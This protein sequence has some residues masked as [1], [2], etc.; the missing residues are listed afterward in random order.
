M[1]TPT[2]STYHTFPAFSPDGRHLA[3][4]SCVGRYSC[5]VAVVE[6][7]ADFVPKGAP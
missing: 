1:T 2:G 3:Y 6:L 7:G 5:Q 4:L